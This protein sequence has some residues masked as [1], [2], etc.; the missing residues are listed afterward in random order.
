MHPNMTNNKI[1]KWYLENFGI[2][3]AGVHKSD[4]SEDDEAGETVM[5]YYTTWLDSMYAFH[6]TKGV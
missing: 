6:R 4:D 1:A 5:P 2:L 3:G